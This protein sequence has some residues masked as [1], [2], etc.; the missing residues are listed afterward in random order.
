MIE[1][2]N[3]FENLLNSHRTIYLSLNFESLWER[4]KNSNRPLVSNGREV[5]ESRYKNRIKRYEMME[6]KISNENV[7]DTT[8][9]V[10]EIMETQ[11]AKNIYLNSTEELIKHINGDLPN[12]SL[13]ILILLLSNFNYIATSMQ[14]MFIL[15]FLKKQK[16]LETI[17]K[18]WEIMF[19]SNLN[20]SDEVVIIGG[21]VML[22]LCSFAASTYK[23]GVA[24]TLVPSTLLAMVDAS[25][26]GKTVLIMFMEKTRLEL[27]IC[28]RVLL[29]V[30]NF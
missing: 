7:K 19:L 30:L 15:K 8:S 29:C 2:D 3:I 12:E 25:H 21:G 6:Y 18:I 22:D 24:F 5:L 20:R 4:I 16:N 13:I 14:A 26:G 28:Q 9:K 27:L 17:E 10:L 11:N 23:R 1:N